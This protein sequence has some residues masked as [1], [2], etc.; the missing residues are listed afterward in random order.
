MPSP[1][2]VVKPKKKAGFKTTSKKLRR[3]VDRASEKLDDPSSFPDVRK[4]R[5][6]IRRIKA[7]RGLGK[8]ATKMTAKEALADLIQKAKALG[9]IPGRM[10]ENLRS[11]ER[12]SR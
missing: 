10:A 7:R 2:R 8:K 12:K 9:S 5:E 6:V 1:G 4:R 3:A 11:I